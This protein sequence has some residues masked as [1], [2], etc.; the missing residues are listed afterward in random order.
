ME[1]VPDYNSLKY[2]SSIE[3]Y[4]YCKLKPRDDKE[5]IVYISF[6]SKP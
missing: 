5:D 1:K 2:H 6:A 3:S 4:I